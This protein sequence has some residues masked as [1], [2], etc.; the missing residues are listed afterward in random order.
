MPCGGGTAQTGTSLGQFT[1]W[2]VRSAAKDFASRF[3]FGGGS[4]VGPHQSLPGYM[5]SHY[6]SK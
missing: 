2:G 5:S 1:S 3:G 4:G 6:V